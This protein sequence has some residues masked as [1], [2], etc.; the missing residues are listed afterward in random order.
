MS[1]TKTRAELVDMV[2]ASISR[3]SFD[4]VEALATIAE[5]DG[6]TMDALAKRADEV[7]AAEACAELFFALAMNESGTF[8]PSQIHLVPSVQAGAAMSDQSRRRAQA[9]ARS[10]KKLFNLATGEQ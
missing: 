1:T 3:F 7:G 9:G 8:G 4:M 10:I 2:A 5:N 6:A